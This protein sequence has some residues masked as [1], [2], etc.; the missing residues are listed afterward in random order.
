MD[1]PASVLERA[2]WHKSSYSGAQQGCVEVA[3][4][5]EVTAVRD[6]KNRQAGILTFPRS[7]WLNFSRRFNQ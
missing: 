5:P 3:E 6:T 7:S 2:H 1:V 4:L